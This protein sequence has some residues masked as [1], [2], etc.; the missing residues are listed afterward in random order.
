M[1]IGS[2]FV[3]ITVL[4]LYLRLSAL[5]LDVSLGRHRNTLHLFTCEPLDKIV[6]MLTFDLFVRFRQI[7]FSAV[8]AAFVGN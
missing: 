4:N 8:Y 1:G 7:L 3:G 6:K 2:K 5:S